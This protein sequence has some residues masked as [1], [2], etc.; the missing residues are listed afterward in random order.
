MRSGLLHDLLDARQH[1]VELPAQSFQ[2]QLLQ[3]AHR[4]LHTRASPEAVCCPTTPAG[5]VQQAAIVLGQ[6]ILTHRASGSP[7]DLQKS[8][9]RASCLIAQPG[10]GRS[11]HGCDLLHDAGQHPNAVARLGAVAWVMDIS[12]NHRCIHTRI[13]RPLVT[14][15]LSFAILI[16]CR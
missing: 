14:R 13:R 3:Q 9:F 8:Q 4:S 16:M 15:L 5:C 11:G 10:A 6:L 2:H 1:F 12:L 7:P